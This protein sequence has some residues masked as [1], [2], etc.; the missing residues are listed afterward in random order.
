MTIDKELEDA[1]TALQLRKTIGL[2]TEDEVA[3]ALLLNSTDTLATWRSQKKGPHFVKLGKRVFYT[4]QDLVQ[5]V[6]GER[7][8]QIQVANDNQPAG[9]AA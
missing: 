2:L 7:E 8:K 4:Q 9:M 3:K 5:W 1:S 6:I